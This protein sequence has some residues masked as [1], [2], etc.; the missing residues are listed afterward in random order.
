MD[1][2]LAGVCGGEAIRLEMLQHLFIEYAS[3]FVYNVTIYDDVGFTL[4]LSFHT[5]S[6]YNHPPISER[7][8]PNIY[9]SNS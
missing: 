9:T 4:S 7:F 8:I 6:G 5:E 3:A 2:Q 1:R